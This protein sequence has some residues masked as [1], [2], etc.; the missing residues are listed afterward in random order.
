MPVA[1]PSYVLESN[2]PLATDDENALKMDADSS[3]YLCGEGAALPPTRL[4][5]VFFTDLYFNGETEDAEGFPPMRCHH[6]ETIVG[7]GTSRCGSRLWH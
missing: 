7:G 1:P 2:M 6:A 3:F 5:P 4:F